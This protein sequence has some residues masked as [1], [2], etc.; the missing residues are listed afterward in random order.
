M[1]MKVKAPPP[2]PVTMWGGFYIGGEAGGGWATSSQT[3]TT[4][5]TS[6]NYN[7]SGGFGG[8]TVGYN[9]QIQNLVWGAEADISAS[10]I[11]GS[12]TLPALC[13]LTGGTVCFTN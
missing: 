1:P 5:V 4:G 9:W 12:V 7:Q 6:G 10:R 11:N 13:S 3:D 8:L 2:P